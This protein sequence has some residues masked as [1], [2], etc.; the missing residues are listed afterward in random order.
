[1]YQDIIGY[2]TNLG[3]DYDSDD[4]FYDACSGN[5]TLAFAQS[6]CTGSDPNSIDARFGLYINNLANVAALNSKVSFY[7][8]TQYFSYDADLGNLLP[9]YLQMRQNNPKSRVLIYSGLSDVNTC[10]FSFAMPCL[11]KL[12]QMADLKLTKKWDTYTRDGKTFGNWQQNEWLTYAT[13]RGAGH[14]VPLVR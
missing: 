12:A 7:N 4:R 13:I 6:V 9:Y 2:S 10:P 8:Q 11:Y 1:M 14:E 3:A 5:G